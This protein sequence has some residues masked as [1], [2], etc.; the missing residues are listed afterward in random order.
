MT[1][2]RV[3]ED[4]FAFERVVE[5]FNRDFITN[6]DPFGGTVWYAL[7]ESYLNLG[8]NDK[9][10]E[11]FEKE[12]ERLGLLYIEGEKFALQMALN[13]NKIA[14]IRENPPSKAYRV[15]ILRLP[16]NKKIENIF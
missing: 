15:T 5:V 14:K 11:A 8:L 12:K 6:D 9:A 1:H 10:S 7:A 2:A 3:N 13:L 16:I 4:Y